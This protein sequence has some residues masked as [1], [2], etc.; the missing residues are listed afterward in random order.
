MCDMT[1]NCL[2]NILL[3]CRFWPNNKSRMY[4][5]ENTR[6]GPHS[7]N[8]I[9]YLDCEYFS[10]IYVCKTYSSGY[11]LLISMMMLLC[12]IIT[13]SC[14][15]LPLNPSFSFGLIGD[16][17]KTHNLQEGDFLMIYKDD[18]TG[19]YVSFGSLGR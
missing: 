17:V 10:V 1:I 9:I 7:L 11:Q 15:L 6:M 3:H 4:L 19:K 16:F 12:N 14:H 18:R 5:L 13:I 8:L 2:I